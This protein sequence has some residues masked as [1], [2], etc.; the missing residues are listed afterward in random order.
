MEKKVLQSKDKT[1]WSG[2]EKKTTRKFKIPEI[3]FWPQV[4]NIKNKKMAA[5]LI[6]A[7]SEDDIYEQFFKNP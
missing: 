4:C 6:S 3:Y 7:T 2:L 5:I 1:L